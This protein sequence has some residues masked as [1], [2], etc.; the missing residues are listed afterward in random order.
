MVSAPHPRF[1]SMG[2]QKIRPGRRTGSLDE[3]GSR[4]GP[5]WRGALRVL[6]AGVCVFAAGCDDPDPSV[7]L[8]HGE[9]LVLSGNFH[10]AIPALKQ[11]LLIDPCNP[12]AHYYLGQAYLNAQFRASIPPWRLTVAL[13]ELDTALACFKRLGRPNVLARFTGKQF[14]VS[15]HL[16]K[17]LVHLRRLQVGASHGIPLHAMRAIMDELEGEADAAR[18]ILPDSSDV[19]DLDAL[20]AQFKELDVPPP[21]LAAPPSMEPPQ[22]TAVL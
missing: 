6:A 21:P 18:A 4:R 20:I 9:E 13:G 3:A 12:G 1:E 10:E 17:A 5:A 8:D 7:L 16:K 19:M 22:P 14:E 2:Q 15:C 11:C